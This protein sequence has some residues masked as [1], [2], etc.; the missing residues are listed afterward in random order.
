VTRDTVPD[1]VVENLNII[2]IV[3][4]CF[5]LRREKQETED[6]KGKAIRVTGREGP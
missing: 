4:N 5:D 1:A 6:I 2:K 3:I